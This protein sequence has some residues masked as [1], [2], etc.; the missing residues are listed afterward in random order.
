M[1]L[2]ELIKDYRVWVILFFV[3]RLYHISNPPLEVAH[4]WRQTTV[5]MAARNFL[6]TDPNILLPR[7][8]IAGEKTG[9]TAME[10]PLLNYCIYLISLVFGYAHWYG[11]LINL[12]VSSFGLY[13]FY[14][15][16][17]KYGGESLAF[18]SALILLFSIWFSYSRKIMPDTFS[19][20]LVIIG[21]YYGSNFLDRKN[22]IK[23]L[24][25]YFLFVSGG[26]LSK[27]PSVYVFALFPLVLL[28][29]EID[30]AR[31]IKIATVTLVAAIVVGMYYFMWV[32]HLTA[33]Y[34]FTHFF[35]GTALYQGAQ[36]IFDNLNEALEKFYEDA[37][38]FS[39]FIVFLTAL[40]ILYFKKEKKLFLI[41]LATFFGFLFIVFKSGFAFYHHSY[42][43]IPF[44]P[45]MALLSGYALTKIK[46]QKWV[47]VILACVALESILKK[48]A[49]FYIKEN[50]LAMLSL[51]K[52]LDKFSSR[53]DLIAI[54][55]GNLPTP[56]YFSHR[57]GWIETN[58]VLLDTNRVA[59][60]KVKGLKYIVILKKT[61]S[62]GDIQLSYQILFENS[63]YRIY[64]L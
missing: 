20:S 40:P 7:I 2:K 21:L 6:E 41:F 42:Y 14:K 15:L 47:F 22:S 24:L 49:D 59:D 13:Y 45:V 25:I 4:N 18:N 33:K 38:G 52:D 50:N 39:G 56:M 61:F 53:N 48:N 46:N 8:D 1:N 64:Q 12:I 63:D 62:E 27:L 9:I 32:P 29:K 11:R 17:R 23:N 36:E 58:Q 10:F 19:V 28:E 16:V 57:K 43:I 3:V 34:Q 54:N 31:K 26:L 60:L 44:V 51:E 35:M 37:I 5:T 55:S 30:G